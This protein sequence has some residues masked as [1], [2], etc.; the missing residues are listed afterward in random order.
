LVIKTV[1]ENTLLNGKL[2][3][4]KEEKVVKDIEDVVA[5]D[6]VSPEVIDEAML[7]K[8]IDNLVVV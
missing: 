6:T 7:D 1:R 4:K 5:E 8:S 3:L 2:S